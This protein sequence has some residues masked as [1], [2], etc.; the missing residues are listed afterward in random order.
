VYMSATSR[1]RHVLCTQRRC[2]TRAKWNVCPPYH[3]YEPQKD[4]VVNKLKPIIAEVF[5]L[6]RAR[7]AFEYGAGTH[8]PVINDSQLL[9]CFW[10]KTLPNE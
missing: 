6:A 10:L 1:N 4:R 3:A 5:P 7:E 9:D 8:S 2:L